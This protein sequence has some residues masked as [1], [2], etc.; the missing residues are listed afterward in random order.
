MVLGNDTN[1]QPSWFVN[2]SI[3]NLNLTSAA[4]GALARG[5]FLPELPTDYNGKQRPSRAPTDLGAT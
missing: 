2:E 3:G 4:T 1:A 5:V